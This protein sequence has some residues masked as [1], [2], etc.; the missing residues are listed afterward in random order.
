[1]Q[2]QCIDIY[3]SSS[4]VLKTA[5]PPL[6]VYSVNTENHKDILSQNKVQVKISNKT[7]TSYVLK[8]SN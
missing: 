8:F 7:C 4:E 1:M 6:S 5:K 2:E 3:A